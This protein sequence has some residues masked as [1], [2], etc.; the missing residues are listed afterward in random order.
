MT[1]LGSAVQTAIRR[2]RTAGSYLGTVTAIDATALALTVDI[3]TGT[4]LTGVRWIEPYAP[5][6]DDLVTV[7]RAGSA[8]VV[9]G[10]LSKD[11]RGSTVVRETVTIQPAAVWQ[12]M[13]WWYTSSETSA[14]SWSS[15]GI[16][17][18][19]TGGAPPNA[20]V[21]GGAAIYPPISGYIP[22]GATIETARITMTRTWDDDTLATRS[23]RI[24]GYNTDGPTGTSGPSAGFS[25]GFGPWSPGTLVQGQTSTWALPSTWLTALL[26]G[27]LRGIALYSQAPAD[28]LAVH[29]TLPIT[30]TYRL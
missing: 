1:S 3:G 18:G 21:F 4:P 6:V 13:A 24:Y 16:R 29:A 7:L 19:R 9:L 23:P 14:W 28:S 22:S 25:P 26:S 10:K 2:G 8:W 5:E 12:A 30:I 20:Q 17:Q 11:L 27:T 15:G